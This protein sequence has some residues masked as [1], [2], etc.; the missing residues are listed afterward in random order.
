MYLLFLDESGTH[1]SS[2]AF[3]VAGIAVHEED[4]YYLQRSLEGILL[5]HLTPLGL[6]HH[7]FELHATE[8]KS[9][10]RRRG[11]R[12]GRRGKKAPP[13]SIWTKV[14]AATRFA[15]LQDVYDTLT[16]YVPQDPNYPVVLF[17]AVVDR[18]YKDKSKRA[19]EQVINKFD[20]MLG[21]H[22]HERSVRE[23]GMIVHDEHQ[24][25]PDLQAWSHHWRQ[26][27]SRVGR[28]HNIVH[29]PLFTD[30]RSSRLLQAGDFVAFALWRHYGVHDSDWLTQLLPH[31]DHVD[32]AR[33]GLIH[34]HPTYQRGGCACPP[35]GERAGRV[36]SSS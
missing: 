1:D 10:E 35:C 12:G 15:I 20:E 6:E 28:L 3:I 30:S 18:R 24:V 25:E 23:R 34:V 7:K 5:R 27:G 8:I 14:P 33:H 26:V 21:R 16:S 36:G 19:Y 11:V 29:V 17:G 22:Y 32:G 31:F 2:P 13:V 4:V 9:P